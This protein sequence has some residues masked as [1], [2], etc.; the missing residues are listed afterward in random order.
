MLGHGTQEYRAVVDATFR[1]FAAL[2]IV[3]YLSKLELARGYVL[4]A[5][6]VGLVAV[7]YT[8]LDVYKRQARAYA[9]VYAATGTSAP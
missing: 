3:S 9:Q 4:V 1:L 8:H 2:A 6:P 7:S 5:F